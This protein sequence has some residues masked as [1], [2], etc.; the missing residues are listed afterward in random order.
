MSLVEDRAMQEATRLAKHRDELQIEVTRL[1]EALR[2]MSDA[3]S[4]ISYMCG[5]PNDQHI[6]IYDVAPDPNTV[7]TQVTRA[8]ESSEAVLKCHASPYGIHRCVHCDS[9]ITE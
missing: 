4:R 8:L 9:E 6:S 1:R 7:V 5:P 3:L 2:E